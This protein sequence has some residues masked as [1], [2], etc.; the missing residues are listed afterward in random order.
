MGSL[1]L[2]SEVADVKTRIDA[3]RSWAADAGTEQVPMF[4][5][6]CCA[7]FLGSVRTLNFVQQCVVL[8]LYMRGASA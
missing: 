1:V 3:T 4:S 8:G 7:F 5:V 2:L 6:L